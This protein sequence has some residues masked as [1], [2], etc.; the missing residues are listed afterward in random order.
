MPNPLLNQ[1][2]DYPSK[3]LLRTEV[4]PCAFP[5]SIN[6][7]H[8]LFT[9]GSC[10]ADSIG[11]ILE[12]NK[13]DVCVNP[14][15]TIFNPISIHRILSNSDSGEIIEKQDTC[16]RDDL[17]FSYDHHTTVSGNS[18]V[19]LKKKIKVLTDNI[20]TALDAADYLFIT[21]G[22]AWVY[23][24]RE[25]SKIVANCHKMPADWF[26]RRLLTTE[27]IVKSFRDFLDSLIQRN[28]KIKIIL[29]VS[30]VRHTRDTLELNSVSKSALR[31]ACHQLSNQINIFYFPAYEIMMDD[32]RDYRFYERDLIHPN[33][34]ALD[35]IWEKMIAIS[36]S[37]E[38]IELMKRWNEIVTA[39]N[40]RPMDQSGTA[41]LGFLQK[42]LQQLHWIQSSLKVA[43]EINQVQEKLKLL[44]K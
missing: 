35:Y 14:A 9:A 8:K 7:Q 37:A 1:M 18:V 4:Q 31:L 23:Q 36:M 43:D 44:Q 19:A 29:T 33:S 30:P 6:H 5:F 10:F 38:T 34:V 25:S 26:T 2:S 21:Y 40:H 27:E 42:T 11:K 22:T 16:F 32:L 20:T 13:F 15:G 12:K 3:I 17:F 41:Y 39:L 28:P 24:L